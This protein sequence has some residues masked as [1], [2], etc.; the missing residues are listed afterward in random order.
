MDLPKHIV[1]YCLCEFL[2]F[3]ARTVYKHGFMKF[4]SR[5]NKFNKVTL[6]TKLVDSVSQE[7]LRYNKIIHYQL[8][9]YFDNDDDNDDAFVL[10]TKIR[11][12]TKAVLFP[13]KTVIE[14]LNDTHSKCNRRMNTPFYEIEEMVC[15]GKFTLLECLSEFFTLDDMFFISTW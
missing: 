14:F 3:E 9:K 5:V 6:E 15:T 12:S 13:D 4:D 2:P 1:D 11:I 7:M 8:N 10:I